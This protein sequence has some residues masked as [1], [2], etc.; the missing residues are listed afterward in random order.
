MATLSPPNTRLATPE[1]NEL[2]AGPLVHTCWGLDPEELHK[3]YWASY[4]VQVVRVGEPGAVVSQAELYLLLDPRSLPMFRLGQEVMDALNWVEPTVLFLRLTDTRERGYRERIQIAEDEPATSRTRTGLPSDRFLRYQRLYDAAEQRMSRV[5]LT[6]D[7]EIAHL[8]LASK[9]PLKGWQRLRRFVPREE[10]ATRRIGAR[11]YDRNEDR[12]VALMLKRLVGE[13]RRP[14]ATIRRATYQPNVSTRRQR[15]APGSA[16]VDPSASIEGVRIVGNVWVGAGRRL[17]KGRTIVG[18]TVLWD[19]PSVRPRPEE[20]GEVDWLTLDP[21]S[22]A[23][24]LE[25]PPKPREATLDDALK[26]VFDITFSFVALL[27]TV[28]TI[29]PIIILGIWLEDGG[30]PFYGHVRQTRGGRN[31]KCWKFRSMYLNSDERKKQLIA[32]GKNEAD[33]EQFYMENDPRVTRI[34]RLL[35]KTNL[36]ELPQFW[37]VLRGEMSVVGPR[38]SPDK[39]NQ[40]APGWREVR[41]SVLPGITGLWQLRR[42]RAEGQ[43]LEEWIRYDLEYVRT[44]TFLGD[45]Q[46]I[47][48]TVTMMLRKLVRS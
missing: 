45:L 16:W 40:L 13:W 41:L 10:R 22:A 36:D 24:V 12:D 29:W 2:S 30:K 6:P 43:P 21:E 34:G 18:P 28:P 8:W 14:H 42:T 27:V 25:I 9:N 15:A 23:D 47:W 32:E 19:D 31:F 7:P 33:G 44:R 39:E 17:E 26:R 48:K 20:V 38:P 35:R 11:I 46:L 37:N 1:L 3:R 4:G 5:A